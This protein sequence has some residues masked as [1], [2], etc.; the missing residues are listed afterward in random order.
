M[1]RFIIAIAWLVSLTAASTAFWQ[2]RD[3]NYNT[4]ISAGGSE[5]TVQ[6]DATQVSGTSSTSA[7]TATFSGANTLNAGSGPNGTTNMVLAVALQFCQN[8][9]GTSVPT[10]VQWDSTGGSPQTML[11]ISRT[12][13]GGD[14]VGNASAGDIYYY[15]VVAPHLGNLGLSITWTGANQL[16]ASQATF[17]NVDQTGGNTTFPSVIGA[18]GTGTVPTVNISTSPTTRKMMG[19]FA[20]GTTNFTTTGSTALTGSPQNSCNT[21]ATAASWDVGSVSSLAYSP[22][23]SG[24][25]AALGVVIKGH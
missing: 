10:A 25:W 4:A 6:I 13:A 2:S 19:A 18:T 3:T 11:K 16:I 23:S 17:V 9:A 21:A 12:D 14:H 22:S 20:S 8:T 15:A 1:R 24:A 5:A 7:T